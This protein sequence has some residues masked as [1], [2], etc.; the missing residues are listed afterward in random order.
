MTDNTNKK[1]PILSTKEELKTFI[2]QSLSDREKI[3]KR[4]I[5]GKISEEA[6]LRIEKLCGKKISNIDID[7]SGIIHAI[8]KENHNLKPDDL[9]YAVDVINTTKDIA[10]SD[11]KHQDCDV[12]L[13]RK[14]ING[15]ITF[16]TEAH[17]AKNYL[18]VFNAW[19]QKKARRSPSA[20]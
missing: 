13:F 18:L 1:V 15:E 10:L 7:K 9:L 12:L 17:I 14:N 3:N 19:R 6:Q 16:L 4:V 11:K 5:I 20:T 8:T 2:I